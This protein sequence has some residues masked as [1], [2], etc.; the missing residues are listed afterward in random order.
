[1]LACVQWLH[2]RLVPYMLI[3]CSALDGQALLS[4]M[5]HPSCIAG[6]PSNSSGSAG[7]LHHWV[8]KQPFHSSVMHWYGG[9]TD[10][11]CQ[12]PPICGT[13]ATELTACFAHSSLIGGCSWICSCVLSRSMPKC[14]T[15]QQPWLT[16]VSSGPA[17]GHLGATVIYI[18]LINKVFLPALVQ[19][20]SAS[21]AVLKQPRAAPFMLLSHSSLQA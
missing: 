4:C 7:D 14:G 15:P 1:M 3:L 19:A 12:P 21:P 13:I 2:A 5:M 6:N 16:R 20:D 10:S 17:K 11:I 18:Y 9:L 8:L